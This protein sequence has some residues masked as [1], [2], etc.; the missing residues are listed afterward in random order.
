M[1]SALSDLRRAWQCRAA[2]LAL[3]AYRAVAGT[4]VALP[5]WWG[6]AGSG[7]ARHP[8]GDAPLF[9]PGGALLVEWVRL[10]V[11]ALPALGVGTAAALGLCGLVGLMPLAF[12]LQRLAA[13]R[14]SLLGAVPSLALLGA[15]ALLLQTLL[16]LAGLSLGL[17]LEDAL[18]GS[19]SERTADLASAAVFGLALGLGALV[20]V[21]RDLGRAALVAHADGVGHALALAWRGFASRPMSAVVGWATPAM[22]SVALVLAAAWLVGRIDVHQPGAHRVLA[23]LA[24]HQGAL[25]GV[26][27]LQSSWLSRAIMLSAAPPVE[28]A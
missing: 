1:S 14:A 10:N 2:V 3:W 13:R 20:G 21:L 5:A 19:R 17:N 4:L 15:G 9:D 6:V 18:A 24:V 8:R 25:F 26:T 11:N 23:V 22:W 16:A 28:D 12:L 7:F 27:L